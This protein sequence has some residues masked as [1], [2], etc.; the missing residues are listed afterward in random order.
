ASSH[1]ALVLLTAGH[2]EVDKLGHEFERRRRT[3][4]T[5]EKGKLALR[6]GH[7]LARLGRLKKPV[8]YPA[9]DAV[10]EGEAK[11]LLGR[12]RIE[13]DEVAHLVA[14]TETIRADNADFESV[15]LVLAERAAQ[16][17][18]RE[19]EELFARLRHSRLDLLGPG[20][21]RAALEAEL[22]TA[23]IN[24]RQI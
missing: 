17:A 14:R 20:G 18:K 4:D 5:V 22:E 11:E 16:P 7:A 1:D 21:R 9:A 19:E 10:L 3:A 2:N 23:P 12:L 15:V 24:R 13:Q 6:L 8:F